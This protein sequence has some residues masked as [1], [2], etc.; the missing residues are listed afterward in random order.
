MTATDLLSTFALAFG[1]LGF[2][3][4]LANAH[5]LTI[6]D[7]KQTKDE[8]EQGIRI[9]G[10]NKAFFD[11]RG[12]INIEASQSR[13]KR[14]ELEQ[15]I[16]ELQ[17]KV[18]KLKKSLLTFLQGTL[19]I[20]SGSRRDSREGLIRLVKRNSELEKLITDLNE[21]D[22]DDDEEV[23][24]KE[25]CRDC[26]KSPEDCDCEE[27]EVV[28]DEDGDEEMCLGCDRPKEDCSCKDDVEED[29]DED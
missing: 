6:H 27:A 8:K 9:A 10:L 28:I 1:V 12:A 11:Q 2:V 3:F 25:R 26:G 17:E 16:K 29:E 15:E 5:R 23:D 4:G 24:E 19:T 21:E 22:D 18:A 13:L 7:D 14:S 20:S